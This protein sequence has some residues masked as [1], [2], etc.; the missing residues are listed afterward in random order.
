M[1][2]YDFNKLS[3]EDKQAIL[4]KDGEFLDNHITKDEKCNVY[5]LGKFF[6]EVVYDGEHNVIT[7]LRSFKTGHL[8]DKY[9]ID[10]I[11]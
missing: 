7:E 3:L 4:W 8:L 10:F 9:S 6:V 5:A 2:L 11:K 1:T